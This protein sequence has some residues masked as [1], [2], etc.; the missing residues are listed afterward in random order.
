MNRKEKPKALNNPGALVLWPGL[1]G[2]RVMF[3]VA[4]APNEDPYVAKHFCVIDERALWVPWLATPG[5]L[6]VTEL[7]DGE[8]T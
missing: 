8:T 7:F 2:S 4:S 3:V 1:S 6:D 5:S